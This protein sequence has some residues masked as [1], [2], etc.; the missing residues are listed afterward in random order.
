MSKAKFTLRQ[1][2]NDGKLVHIRRFEIYSLCTILDED[3]Y[4]QIAR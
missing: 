1:I 4:T 2:L 3:L